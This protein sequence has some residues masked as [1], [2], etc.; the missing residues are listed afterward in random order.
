MNP[1]LI[2]AILTKGSSGLLERQD[3]N[4]TEY[5]ISLPKLV[6][7]VER[8][9]FDYSVSEVD[10]KLVADNPVVEA[11]DKFKNAIGVAEFYWNNEKIYVG[12]I[13]KFST[14]YD[15]TG[16]EVTLRTIDLLKDRISQLRFNDPLV[17]LSVYNYLLSDRRGLLRAIFGLNA[18][19]Y[20]GVSFFAY[21][22]DWVLKQRDLWSAYQTDK[23]SDTKTRLMNAR[24]LL[25]ECLKFYGEQVW[26]E[27]R[28]WYYV[29]KV[30]PANSVVVVKKRNY[31]PTAVVDVVDYISAKYTYS[32]GLVQYVVLPFVDASRA[33]ITSYHIGLID[34][35]N[36]EFKDYLTSDFLGEIED[37]K[38]YTAVIVPRS[39]YVDN[40]GRMQPS[41]YHISPDGTPFIWQG[42]QY[43]W[44]GESLDDLVDKVSDAF[45]DLVTD[46]TGIEIEL[47]GVDDFLSVKP[48]DFIQFDLNWVK[49]MAITFDFE[50]MKTTIRGNVAKIKTY[51]NL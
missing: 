36:R 42:Y 12:I 22:R 30:Y 4:L 16:K 15:Y 21:S 2:V 10:F 9:A 43:I 31:I 18:P 49:V 3:Y 38:D 40:Y 48:L 39:P 14:V 19:D 46:T 1:Q 34:I 23:S 51:I 25:V 6:K 20:E 47:P 28:E 24:D 45:V 26:V 41:T 27:A 8:D 35:A 33:N 13:D 32:K 5:L 11:F 17:N 29:D 37:I 44:Q 7:E 50:N